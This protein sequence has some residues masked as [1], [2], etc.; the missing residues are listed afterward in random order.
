[1]NSETLSSVFVSS[2]LDYFD[3]TVQQRAECGT[4]YMAIGRSPEIGDYTGIIKVTGVRHGVVLFTAPKAMLCV[5]LMRMQETDMGHENL[6]DLV[7]E[8][9][10]TLCGNARK[11]LGHEFH[12]SVPAV[13]HGR[14]TAIDYAQNARPIVIPIAWRNHHARLVVSLDASAT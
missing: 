5:M 10:N 12:I 7:G 9:A 1:M 13:I 2:V 6:C 3:T 4:P 8:I 14:D 11:Q